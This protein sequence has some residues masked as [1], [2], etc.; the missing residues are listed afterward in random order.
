LE[1][2]GAVGTVMYRVQPLSRT[3]AHAWCQTSQYSWCPSLF[4]RKKIGNLQRLPAGYHG[5]FFFFF[6][7]VVVEVIFYIFLFKNILIK[8]KYLINI[9]INKK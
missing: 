5:C 2:E 6:F 7:G 3:A 8:N 1:E 9:N 4:G